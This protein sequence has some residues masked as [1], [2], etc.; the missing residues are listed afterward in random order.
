MIPNIRVE[1]EGVTIYT[2]S[3]GFRDTEFSGEP[4]PG[5]FLIAVL[6]DSFTFGQGVHQSETFPAV[7]QKFLNQS[8]E[9]PKF[10]VWNLGVSGYNTE[11]E[12][13]LLKSFVLPRKPNWVVV[14]LNVNDYEPIVVDRSL[15]GQEKS[16]KDSVV[17]TIRNFIRYD[18]LITQVV[19]LKFANIVR[20]FSP[21]WTYSNYFQEVMDQYL[22]PNGGWTRVSAL[23]LDMKRESEAAGVG[24]TLAILPVMWDFQNY[25]FEEVND[26]IIDFCKAHK[27]DC[28][29]ILPYF[30]TESPR[31]WSVSSIDTH[32]NSRAQGIF[33]KA[34]ADHFYG[35][36]LNKEP[37]R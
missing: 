9:V 11:Q 32:P 24:F 5:Q 36:I 29:D 28:V 4:E 8:H 15:A 6:G 18:L 17:N 1:R 31:S 23:L 27:I 7:L 20:N 25:L 2:N 12:S 34:L 35:K 16:Y 22:K 13:H 33:A 30:K 10:R 26:V 3:D 19:L 14:G 37:Q 21:N